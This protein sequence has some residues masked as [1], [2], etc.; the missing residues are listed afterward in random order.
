MELEFPALEELRRLL[1]ETG[2]GQVASLEQYYESSIFG[3][4]HKRDDERDS[5]S[6]ASTATCVLSLLATGRWRTDNR[7]KQPSWSDHA[8]L[9]AKTLLTS[10]WKSAGLPLNNPFTVAFIL[11]TVT[12]LRDFDRNIDLQSLDPR[13]AERVG[14]GEEILLESLRTGTKDKPRGAACIQEYPPSAYLTQLVVRVLKARSRLDSELADAVKE[15]ALREI[16]RQVTLLVSD[17]RTRDVYSLA[18]STILLTSLS[19]PSKIKPE[20]KR[21]QETAIQHLFASQ[22][23][24]GSWPP[25][26]PLFHYPGVGNAYCFEYEMLVQLLQTQGLQEILLRHM[27]ALNRSMT[28][29]KANRFDLGDGASGWAS[30]HHP[31]LKGPESWSTAS[32]FHFVHVLDRL[33]SEAVRRATFRYLDQAYHPPRTPKSNEADFAED[34]L[35]CNIVVRGREESLRKTLWT[36]FVEPIAKNSMLVEN[37]RP[38]PKDVAMTAILFGPPGTSKTQLARLVGE[39]LQWPL[40]VVDPSHLVRGGMDQIQAEANTIFGMLEASE[41]MVVLLDEFDEMVRD[42]ASAQSEA[43][44]RF[45]TTAMLP[46]LSRINQRRRIVFILAT[47]YIDHFDFAIARPG[48]FDVK[49]Q[50]MPPTVDEKLKKWDK[51]M[52][53]LQDLKLDKDDLVRKQLGTLT[54]DELKEC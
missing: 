22:L 32:V 12:A 19:D 24:D 4:K 23:P 52:Q 48:R 50:V 14:E 41:R 6:K 8:G 29:L 35:D 9:V 21:I 47:N 10:E 27:D 17:A 43:T 20:E 1:A 44:S 15:W 25:S 11:E 36:H 28:A 40:L 13:C 30:G 31:Q 16:T 49:L 3:F 18:Y 5:P 34:F 51:V 38:L 45:L 46:K 54:Y 37:G 26:R 53:K 7:D 39:F 33:V 2:Q 42:R